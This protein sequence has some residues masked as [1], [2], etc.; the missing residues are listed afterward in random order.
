MNENQTTHFKS[1]KFTGTKSRLPIDSTSKGVDERDEQNDSKGDEIMFQHVL[2]F[3]QF[4]SVL[5][6]E[7]C[8]HLN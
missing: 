1:A 6:K 5:H 2:G 7:V 4:D 8:F 3:H